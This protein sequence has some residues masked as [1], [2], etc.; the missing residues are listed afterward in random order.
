MLN[1]LAGGTL[2]ADLS[3]FELK[4]APN[5]VARF[6][7]RYDVR[8]RPRSKLAMLTGCPRQMR[9][10]AIHSQAIDRLGAGF[11]VAA[12]EPNGVIQAVE[13]LSEP[14]WIGVQFHP[15]FLIYRAPFRR[16]FRAL[17]EAADARAQSR[18][19]EAASVEQ[20]AA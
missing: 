12:R 4:R 3:A 6:F 16:L 8:V 20:K 10:N 9:V 19:A 15:E 1:V 14:F 7:E 2:H 11:T 13:D 18:R 17:V 5:I